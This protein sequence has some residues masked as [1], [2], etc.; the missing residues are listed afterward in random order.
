MPRRARSRAWI[1]FSATSRRH[2]ASASPHFCS[3]RS[4]TTPCSI[5]PKC[6]NAD[7]PQEFHSPRCHPLFW[8]VLLCALS[9]LWVDI[10]KGQSCCGEAAPQLFVPLK[11]DH[12]TQGLDDPEG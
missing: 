6:I 9:I 1:G 3:L 7:G 5:I 4:S 8:E 12:L 10:R 2:S 11:A